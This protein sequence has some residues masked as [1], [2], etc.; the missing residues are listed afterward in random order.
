V[1]AYNNNIKLNINNFNFKKVLSKPLR[2]KDLILK[3]FIINKPFVI[4]KGIK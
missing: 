1:F 3:G 4:K 2:A